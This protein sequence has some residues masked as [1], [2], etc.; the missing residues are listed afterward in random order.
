ML[1]SVKRVVVS[2]RSDVK[3]LV[4]STE[5]TK[6]RGSTRKEEEIQSP[7]KSNETTPLSRREMNRI[8]NRTRKTIGSRIKKSALKSEFT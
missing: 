5:K 6:Q 7:R 2:C 1:L 4:E 8:D 3:E